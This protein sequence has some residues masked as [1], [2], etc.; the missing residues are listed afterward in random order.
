MKITINDVTLRDGLQNEPYF[1]STDNKVKLIN[2]IID[3]G[4]KYLEITSFVNP[5]L[6]PQLKDSLELSTH[7]ELQPAYFSALVPNLKGFYQC[8]NTKIKEAVLFISA[9]EMH[10]LKNLNK[11]I[12]ESLLKL[13]DIF[14]EAKGCGINFRGAISMV[15]GS[16]FVNGLPEDKELFKIIDFFIENEVIDITLSDTWGNANRKLFE[17]Q[18]MKILKQFDYDNFSVHLHD[19]KGK[20]IINAEVAVD[21]GIK[22]FDTSF[23]GL[24]GCPFSPEKGGNLNIRDLIRIING[25]GLKADI[26]DSKF[27]E[28]EKFLEKLKLG[29]SLNSKL[30]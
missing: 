16:P 15:F 10:N 21:Y 6:I 19:I 22:K 7:S 25:K 30:K 3:A 20:G 9:C 8:I 1:V 29:Q 28:I 11:T 14:I 17:K 4:I 26:D 23:K 2:M 24:G 5:R 13:K 18:L 12:N 27:L